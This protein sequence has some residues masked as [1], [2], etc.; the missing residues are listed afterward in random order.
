MSLRYMM[1]TVG[2]LAVCAPNR[3]ARAGD[4]AAIDSVRSCGH[5]QSFPKPDIGRGCR[6]QRSAWTSSITSAD[7]SNRHAG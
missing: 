2:F 7:R 6:A 4:V 3:K 1:W 5:A